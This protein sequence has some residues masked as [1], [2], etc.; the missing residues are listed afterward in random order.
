MLTLL[1]VSD[2]E[3]GVVSLHLPIGYRDAIPVP[4]NPLPDDITTASSEPVKMIG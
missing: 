2:R 1:E 4:T 3:E